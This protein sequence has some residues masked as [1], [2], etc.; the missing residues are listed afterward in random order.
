MTLL[1]DL[2]G[3]GQ[4]PITCPFKD[5]NKYSVFIFV[6]TF[7]SNWATVAFSVRN[8]FRVVTYSKDL[9]YNFALKYE[10]NAVN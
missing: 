1:V 9:I 8:Q 4:G 7:L 5:G 3:S 10:K 2:C 6:R